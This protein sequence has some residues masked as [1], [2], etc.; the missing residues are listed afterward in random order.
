VVD[1]ATEEATARALLGAAEPLTPGQRQEA[2]DS[3]MDLLA[4]MV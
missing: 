3:A 2:A 1:H 4:G